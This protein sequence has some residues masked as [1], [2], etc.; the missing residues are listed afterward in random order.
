VIGAIDFVPISKLPDGITSSRK[1][2]NL[3]KLLPWL[4]KKKTDGKNIGLKSRIESVE[5][6][7]MLKAI[8][9]FIGVH[10]AP[11]LA[12]LVLG[13]MAGVRGGALL[14]CVVIAVIAWIMFLDFIGDQD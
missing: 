14:L 9:F 7:S 11:P 2:L 4:G 12:M 8:L 1:S 3:M 6:V 10:S 13:Y 5:E